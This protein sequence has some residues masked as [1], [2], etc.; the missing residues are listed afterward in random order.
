MASTRWEALIAGASVSNCV[1]SGPMSARE[2]EIFMVCVP[3]G[4]LSFADY[5]TAPRKG[6]KKTRR[7]ESRDL[8]SV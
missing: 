7:S 6:T 8:G 4:G 2:I 5:T 3:C 1:F